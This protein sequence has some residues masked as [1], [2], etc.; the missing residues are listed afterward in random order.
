MTQIS[1]SQSK[2]HALQKK[3]K[4]NKKLE[5]QNLHY[6]DSSQSF[7]FIVLQKD[8]KFQE[9]KPQFQTPGFNL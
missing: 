5:N 6:S 8:K 7:T 1:H 2:L 9:I 3:K 4:Q